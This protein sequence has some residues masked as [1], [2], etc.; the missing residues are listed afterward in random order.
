MAILVHS[1][2]C[3]CT[4]EKIYLHWMVSSMCSIIF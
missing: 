3:K 1:L 4:N 2:T